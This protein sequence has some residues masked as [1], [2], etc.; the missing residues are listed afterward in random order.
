MR[1]GCSIRT[2]RPFFVTISNGRN[3]LAYFN[4]RISSMLIL[5]RKIKDVPDSRNR[6]SGSLK[7]SARPEQPLRNKEPRLHLA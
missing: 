6:V 3:G 5:D 1:I 4:A 2:L 7:P